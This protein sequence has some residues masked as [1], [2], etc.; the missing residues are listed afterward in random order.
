MSR[1]MKRI[2]V[3]LLLGLLLG[4]WAVASAQAPPGEERAEVAD[5]GEPA[6]PCVSAGEAILPKGAHGPPEP[7]A[8][9]CEEQEPEVTPGEE[10]VTGAEVTADE[11][12][13]PGEE[14]HEDYPVPLPADM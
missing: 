11:E 12:F 8:V 9:P 1:T 13:T 2:F 4:A 5:A 3:L 6:L 14:I 10:Q 7:G